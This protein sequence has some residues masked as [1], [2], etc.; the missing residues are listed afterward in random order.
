MDIFIRYLSI[1]VH[2]EIRPCSSFSI[3][4][5]VLQNL[6]H[7]LLSFKLL[8][9]QRSLI[10]EITFDHDVGWILLSL[11]KQRFRSLSEFDKPFKD[12]RKLWK[13]LSVFIALMA[14]RIGGLDHPRR[15][16]VLE[17]IK[18][19]LP[20]FIDLGW[21]CLRHNEE[22]YDRSKEM[23]SSWHCFEFDF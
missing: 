17:V 7:H 6:I 9:H 1:R 18:I 2:S 20:E 8:C 10:L 21:C 14:F 15:I 5:Y 16:S 4:F 12:Y 3:A 19:V 23:V 11:R 13:G 22:Y